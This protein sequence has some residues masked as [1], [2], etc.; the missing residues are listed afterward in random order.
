MTTET[1]ISYDNLPLWMR[2][3]KQEF[4][5][6][7]LIIIAMSFA[8]GWTFLINGELPA[9]TDL[10]HYVFLGSDVL[11][12]FEEG[13]FYPRWSPYAIKGYGAPI[14]NY[15]PMGTSYTVAVV[16]ALFTNDIIQA[17]RLVFVL[18]YVMAGLG[19]YLYLSRRTDSAIG[20]LG[21]V[22]YLYSPMIGSTIPHHMG[23][24]ALLLASGLLPLTLWTAYRL[25]STYQLIDLLLHMMCLGF[26]IWT[27]PQMALI[28]VILNTV[29][30]TIEQGNISRIRRSVR[31]L[32]GNLLSFSLITFYWMPAIFERDL[33]DW[34]PTTKFTKPILTLEQFVAPVTQIDSGLLLPQPQFKAGW[35]LLGFAFIGLVVILRSKSLKTHLYLPIVLG[36]LTLTTLGI[37]VVPQEV[38]LLAPITLCLAII[39]AHT[40]HLRQFLS[41]ERRRLL[42]TFSIAAT[43]IFS[44]PIWL[45]PPANLVTDA[46]GATAQIRF[47][48]LGYGI[49]TLPDGAPLPS[50]IDPNI[51]INRSLINSYALDAPLRYNEQQNN[52]N[53]ILSLL[54]TSSHQQTYRLFNQFPTQIEFMLPYFEGWQAYVNG[55]PIPT[56]ANPNNQQL[57]I[58]VPVTTNGE[59]VIQ[60]QGTPIRNLSWAISI[61]TI[62]L[63]LLLGFVRNRNTTDDM[64]FSLIETLPRTDI[65]LL[66]V[67]F[68]TLGIS[69][70][71]VTSESPIIQLQSPP[72]F[73]FSQSLPLQH[74]S[75]AGFEASTFTIDHTQAQIGDNIAV[76]IYW[77]A[78]TDITTNYQSRILLE[79]TDNRLIW[80]SSDFQPMGPV[81]TRRWLRNRFVA[82]QHLITIPDNVIAGNYQI[83]VEVLPCQTTCNVNSPVIFFDLN[84]T[85]IGRQLII[86]LSITIR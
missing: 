13:V 28:S 38:W 54:S 63:F 45:I 73:S 44:Q 81:P 60:L 52:A 37:F 49:P 55:A 79:S 50:I 20:L 18:A 46:L 8:I 51:A 61:A 14:P 31:L 41:P 48:Q 34:Y 1:T 58:D 19:V 77:Q 47:E 10:E 86:P 71:I 29:M 40:L 68:I 57:M 64:S 76:T 75:S 30:I 33:V 21:S 69:I 72:T 78:L 24:L 70:I 36:A 62:L 6:G 2:H 25:S 27:H 35:I 85:P 39:G 12:G 74:R 3:A 4:D 83:L 22:L 7:I 5:W 53:I 56:Y 26:L 84:G 17:T 9:G 66:L 15:Y 80:Y 43:V 11:T 16:S 67:M 42:L 32:F 82:D 59:L 23:D 65:R